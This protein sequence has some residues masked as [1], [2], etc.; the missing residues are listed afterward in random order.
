[1]LPAMMGSK[2]NTSPYGVDVD[3]LQRLT[4]HLKSVHVSDMPP[5]S[6]ACAKKLFGYQSQ[7]FFSATCWPV[8][9][10]VGQS[11]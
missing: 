1:M 7:T 10:T 6:Q 2:Q 9:F 5:V 3:A 11:V 8:G 4:Q